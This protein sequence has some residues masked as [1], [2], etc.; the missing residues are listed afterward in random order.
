MGVLLGTELSRTGF[1]TLYVT[2]SDITYSYTAH[3]T[4]YRHRFLNASSTMGLNRTVKGVG[5]AKR[6]KPLL[7]L[8]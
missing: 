8:R 4:L 6:L 1:S 5:G 3:E 7:T 2:Y